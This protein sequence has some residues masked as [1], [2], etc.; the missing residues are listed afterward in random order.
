MH[1]VQFEREN[2]IQY[3]AHND[4]SNIQHMYKIQYNIIYRTCV[5]IDGMR[6]G[7]KENIGIDYVE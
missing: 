1:R 3:A 7:R 4:L 6:L 5:F 2:G